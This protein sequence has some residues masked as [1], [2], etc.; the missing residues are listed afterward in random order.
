MLPWLVALVAVALGGLVPDLAMLRAQAPPVARPTLSGTAGTVRIGD[1]FTTITRGVVEVPVLVRMPGKADSETSPEALAPE[2]TGLQFVIDYDDLVLGYAWF[3]AAGSVW[4]VEKAVPYGPHRMT[5]TLER[6]LTEPLGGADESA[7]SEDEGEDPE[8]IALV[9]VFY[10]KDPPSGELPFRQWVP[11][12]LG[13]PSEGVSPFTQLFADVAPG[14]RRVLRTWSIPGSATVYYL[15]GVE[16]GGGGITPTEQDVR[17][18][19]YLTDVDGGRKTFSIGIDYDEIFLN[20]RGV[21]PRSP[22]L[23]SDPLVGELAPEGGRFTFS[24]KLDEVPE[25]GFARL[26]VADL[27][28]RYT[29]VD[30]ADAELLVEP[31]IL[32]EEAEGGDGAAQAPVKSANRVG[33]EPG[34]ITILPSR[35]TRGNVDVSYTLD[36]SGRAR[37]TVDTA[38]VLLLLRAIFAGSA[39]LPCLD[40][41]DVNDSGSLD[42]SDAVH[43]LNHLFRGGPAPL[44]PFPEAGADPTRRDPLDCETSLPAFEPQRGAAP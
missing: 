4:T 7:E 3:R 21:E 23:S 8:T 9:A 26:H 15:D 36:A 35:F 42:L 29:G 12:T 13:V 25:Q 6:N 10:V 34:R 20:S 33:S 38:D 19:L 5:F 17:L 41:A 31:R 24:L 16:V 2:P 32:Q 28:F 43:L 37:S 22:P 30:P 27:I 39:R 11:L 44:A 18:P 40:A 14:V 1:C